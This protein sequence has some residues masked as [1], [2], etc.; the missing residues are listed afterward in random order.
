MNEI[1]GILS[2]FVKGALIDAVFIAILSSV[3]L[4]I[5]GIDFAVFIG[6]FAGISNI[7]PYFG[8]I[9]GMI[10]AFISGW[11]GGGPGR[12]VLSVI[13][14]II[15]QQIDSNIIYPKVVGTST[16]LHP[17]TVLLAVSVFG[18]FGGVPAMLVAVPATGIL[19]VFIIKWAESRHV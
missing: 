17:L 6:V 10:P 4:Y 15:V 16:G 7:I 8:P 9:I 3:A 18:Y 19:Q 12:A 13:V 2:R 1:N 11:C 5:I 14:L